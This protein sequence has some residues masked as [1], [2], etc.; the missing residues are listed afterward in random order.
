M[1]AAARRADAAPIDAANRVELCCTVQ[2]EASIVQGIRDACRR[3]VHPG[4]KGCRGRLLE[5]C[6]CEQHARGGAVCSRWR[7]RFRG[8]FRLLLRGLW[9]VRRA[10]LR[11]PTGWTAPLLRDTPA[12]E[13]HDAA[14]LRIAQWACAVPFDAVASSV[15]KRGCHRAFDGGHG[16]AGGLSPRRVRRTAR[17]ATAP[18]ARAKLSVARD[19]GAG[20]RRSGR[21]GAT[22][23]ALRAGDELGARGLQLAAHAPQSAP[24]PS[25][26]V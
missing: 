17:T 24:E 8:P 19:G 5:C 20:T 7:H 16:A 11:S 14:M 23:D 1:V 2:G 21:D 3:D 18:A 25:H 15:T 9:H 22:A 12:E 13:C 26:G 4:D 6:E 10:R